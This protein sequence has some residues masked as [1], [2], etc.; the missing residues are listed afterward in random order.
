MPTASNTYSLPRHPRVWWSRVKYR[1]PF[2]IWLGAIVAAALLYLETGRTIAISGVIEVVRE[3]A[4]P[5]ETARVS[6][7]P[8]RPGQHVLPGDVLVH[9][10]TS[11]LM[12]ERAQVEAQ[13]ALDHLQV[14]RQF[15][16]A[17]ADA[18][19]RLREMKLRQAM[20]E[21]R[22]EVLREQLKSLDQVMNLAVEDASR[23]AFYRAEAESL[24][25]GVALYPDNIKALEDDLRSAREQLEVSRK[26]SLTTADGT[27]PNPAGSE[28]AANLLASLRMREEM[29]SLRARNTGTVSLVVQAAGDTVGA[30]TPIV[31]S[32]VQGSQHVI[33]YVPESMAH[34]I[35]VGASATI[36]RPMQSAQTYAARVTVLGP[37]I[38]ALPARVS[39]VP[40][41]TIRGRRVVLVIEQQNDFLPGESVNIYLNQ[42]WWMERY[43]NLFQRFVLKPNPPVAPTSA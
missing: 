9:L 14:E 15:S 40:G 10:D 16:R 23:L 8:V 7:I 20:D 35:E 32:V 2:L 11:A 17:V 30:G 43:R 38:L 12:A 1:W 33:G 21:N 5:I 25:R 4:S 37:E 22:L 26:W 13:L 24:A 36:T 6:E 27:A 41:Q 28:A 29:Y 31:I 39:P 19:L 34:R 18:E 3:E 42:P